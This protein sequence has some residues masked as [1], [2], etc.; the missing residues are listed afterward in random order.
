MI[1]ASIDIP[2]DGNPW[3]IKHKIDAWLVEEAEGATLQAFHLNL[4]RNCSTAKITFANQS[5]LLLF[6]L[7]WG[8]K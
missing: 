8:G 7:T 5:Q 6:K 3:A 2:Y 4:G 1:E